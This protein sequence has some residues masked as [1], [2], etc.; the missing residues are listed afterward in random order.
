M[1]CVDVFRRVEV[2]H[3]VERTER[4]EGDGLAYERNSVRERIIEEIIGECERQIGGKE[5]RF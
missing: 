2:L 3:F 1:R 5:I 4:R